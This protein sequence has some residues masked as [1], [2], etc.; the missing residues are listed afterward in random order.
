MGVVGAAIK[1]F[2][3][4]LKVAG[5]NKASK[6]VFNNPPYGAKLQ[7]PVIKSVK[8]AK[9]LTSRRKDQQSMFKTVDDQYKKV[10]VK[11]GSGASKIKKDAAKRVSAIHDKYEKAVS[12]TK[13]YN[14]KVIG[15]ASAGVVGVV[16]A[17][18]AAKHKF[19]KYK[20]FME[21]D[22]KIKDGKVKLVPKKKK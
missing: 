13:K 16:G 9:N 2:G 19:P 7:H 14:K 22:I 18:G 8:P 12:D 3:K 4:A 10:G 21:R 15:G 5:R 20:K 6:S 17:H 11:P 1:G